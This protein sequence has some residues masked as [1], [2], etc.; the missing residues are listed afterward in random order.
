MKTEFENILNNYLGDSVLV[1][2]PTG[3]NPGDD[4]ITMGT[5]KLL[6]QMNIS[7]ELKTISWI[8]LQN[9]FLGDRWK[10]HEYDLVIL[11]GGGYIND[12]WFGG[13]GMIKT[14]AKFSKD[15]IIGPQSCWIKDGSLHKVLKS[16]PHISWFFCREKYSYDAIKNMGLNF[17]TGLTPDCVFYLSKE[18]LEK[19]CIPVTGQKILFCF[20]SDKEGVFKRTPSNNIDLSQMNSVSQYVSII[21]SCEEVHT[22]RLHV[23]CIGAILGKKVMFHES[24]YWKNRGVY[25][26][27]LRAFPN[28]H[29]VPT[30]KT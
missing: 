19:I 27:S 8:S 4:L 26:Y 30:P 16:L 23:A 1:V 29:F 13:R 3:G 12:V 9:R 17:A 18:E 2:N 7:N 22:D 21:E 11:R 10:F 14:I 5:I 24:S 20:R 6:S 25:E 28:V 15:F